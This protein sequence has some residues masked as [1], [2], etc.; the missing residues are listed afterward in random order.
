MSE[1][2]LVD[3]IRLKALPGN[4]LWLRFSDGQEGEWDFSALLRKGGEMVE[5]LRD[6]S[7]FARAFVELGAPTWPNGFDVDPTHLHMQMKE[8]G[9]LTHK[10]A[11]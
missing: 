5:P 8:A 7:L 11:A 3:V 1:I 6:P 10:A 2:I 4:R 9:V